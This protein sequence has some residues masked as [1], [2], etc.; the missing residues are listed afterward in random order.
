MKNLLLAAI[1]LSTIACNGSGGGPLT[2]DP[3]TKKLVHT[4]DHYSNEECIENETETLITEC[5]DLGFKPLTE[6]W[7]VTPSHWNLP[8][9]KLVDGVLYHKTPTH[10]GGYHTQWSSGAGSIDLENGTFNFAKLSLNPF[11]TFYWIDVAGFVDHSTAVFS[12]S[13]IAERDDETGIITLTPTAFTIY[14]SVWAS[15][16]SSMTYEEYKTINELAEIPTWELK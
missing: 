3:E 6:D 9:F 8:K 1:L 2:V 13:G 4:I 15:D 5:N 11:T 14:A 12:T 16:Y 10:L 7:I